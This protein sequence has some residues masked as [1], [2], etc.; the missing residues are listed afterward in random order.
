MFLKPGLWTKDPPLAHLCG[1]GKVCYSLFVYY[2]AGQLGFYL[3]MAAPTMLQ[4]A[5]CHD[6]GQPWSRKPTSFV[7]CWGMS[8]HISHLKSSPAKMLIPQ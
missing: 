4:S 3:L 1:F 5:P 7:Q 8:Q 6:T 2:S